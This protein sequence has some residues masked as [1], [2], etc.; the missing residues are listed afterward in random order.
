MSMRRTASG[1]A[2]M[3]AK[4]ALSS[5]RSSGAGSESLPPM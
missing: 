1:S 5:S 2:F 4:S 3:R